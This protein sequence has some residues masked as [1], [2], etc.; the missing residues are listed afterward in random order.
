MSDPTAKY[1]V[2]ALVPF[3]IIII[4]VV[5]AYLLIRFEKLKII[6]LVNDIFWGFKDC[7]MYGVTRGKVL[8]ERIFLYKRSIESIHKYLLYGAANAF[9]ILFTLWWRIIFF[10]ISTSTSCK[11]DYD[12]FTIDSGVLVGFPKYQPCTDANQTFSNS[13]TLL[14]LQFSIPTLDNLFITIGVSYGF[15]AL[16]FAIIRLIMTLNVGPKASKIV[17]IVS[18]SIIV[19]LL[20]LMVL[21]M[22][23]VKTFTSWLTN[24]LINYLIPFMLILAIAV[25]I[26]IFGCMNTKLGKLSDPFDNGDFVYYIRKKD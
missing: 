2:L 21:L 4:S 7:F 17:S 24:S 19:L 16:I 14:C 10:Q 13:T 1:I 23:F 5:S 18:I 9:G 12:C 25:A 15:T 8:G 6:D 26:A 11:A 3:L 20:V 22:I